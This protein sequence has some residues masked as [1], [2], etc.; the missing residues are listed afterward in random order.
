MIVNVYAANN[1]YDADV[2]DEYGYF[3]T[4]FKVWMHSDVVTILTGPYF[5]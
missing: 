1:P 2:T 3:P 5:C 4:K